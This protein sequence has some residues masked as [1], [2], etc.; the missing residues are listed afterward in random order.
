MSL[1][2]AEFFYVVIRAAFSKSA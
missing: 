1:L 2:V